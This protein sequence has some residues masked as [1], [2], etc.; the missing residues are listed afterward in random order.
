MVDEIITPGISGAIEGDSIELEES[1]VYLIK[2]NHLSEFNTETDR[3]QARRGLDV[4]S[5]GEVNKQIEEV[6]NGEV[7]KIVSDSMTEHLMKDDPHNIMDKVRQEPF[8]RTDGSTPFTQPQ[9]YDG[10]ATFIV[11]DSHLTTK[12]F[13]TD[14]LNSHKNDKY[15]PH[16]T[17]SLVMNKLEDYVKKD[18]IY[19]KREV[20][21]R[22]TIDKLFA[23]YIPINYGRF[24]IPWEGQS[25][26]KDSHLT[27]KKY[28]DQTISNHVIEYDA[29]GYIALLNERLAK[30]YT[31]NET[32]SRAEV[33]SRAQVDGMVYRLV[34]DAAK[35]AL[36]EHINQSDPHKI[37]DIIQ[38]KNFIPRDGSVS[39]T[40]P[41]KGVEGIEDNDLVVLSQL[42]EV[43]N[44]LDL[45]I[46]QAQPVW[47]TSGPVQVTVGFMENNSQVPTEMS[48]QEVLDAIF[49]GKGIS[50]TVPEYVNIADTCKVIACIRGS[51]GM[52]EYAE[53]FQNGKLL[54]SFNKEDFEQDNCM[55]INSEPI[56]EDTEFT[57]KVYYLNNTVHDETKVTKCSIPI[58]IGTLPKWKS[59]STVSYNY[60]TVLSQEDPSNNKFYSEGYDVKEILHEY[61]FSGTDLKHLFIVVPEI[62][63]DLYQMRIPSQQFDIEAFDV[64]NMT[65]QQIPGVPK[66]IIYK[67]Y[68]YR[69][70]VSSANQETIFKFKKQ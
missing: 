18:Q 20:Y 64:I 14:L 17:M 34:T 46:S 38:Y 22:K 39:F 45:S 41:Q 65:P 42:N 15:D 47:K 25:P 3:A 12:K 55:T 62:Y 49:Y 26:V 68:V 70:A 2:D 60:L 9:R 23:S 61:N 31:K 66:D 11:L 28:V 13:V 24:N 33:Y 8:V 44:N 37:L 50:L 43:K 35:T 21:D 6:V 67:M 16:N 30:I 27:T 51:L 53:L 10:D 58:F 40:N 1:P 19:L 57:F 54:F 36:E 59:A 52:I 69:Q 4:Y 29:H 32:Y 5:T 56:F 63:P 48:L 7:K